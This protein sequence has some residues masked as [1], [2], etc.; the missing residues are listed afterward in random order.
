MLT[1]HSPIPIITLIV[2]MTRFKRGS[3][4]SHN[5]LSLP[6][7]VRVEQRGRLKQ[8]T[9]SLTRVC[10]LTVGTFSICAKSYPTQIV[11]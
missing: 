4:G 8:L 5:F 11:S 10:S 9:L 1:L 7:S 3:I 6:T 2:P